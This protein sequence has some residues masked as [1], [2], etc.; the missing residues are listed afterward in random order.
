VKTYTVAHLGCGG[1]GSD[2]VRALAACKPRLKLIALC[3]LDTGRLNAGSAMIGGGPALYT[4][5]EAM[6]AK[7]KPDIFSFCTHPHAR[8]PFV[9]A[10]VRHGVKAIV[11]EKPMALSVQDA[12]AL[13]KTADAAGVKLVVS[14]QHKYGGH[15]QKVK[16]IVASGKIG[17]I[18]TIHATSLGWMQHYATHLIDYSLWLND[19]SPV[20]R[21][22]GHIHGRDYFG[23]GES[24]PS[25]GYFMG[26]LEFA[27][28]V[29]GLVECGT[30]TPEQ[31][32]G[33][34]FWLNAGATVVGTEG[35]A[36]VIVG[37]GWEAVTR[38]GVF[39]DCSVRFDGVKD[40]IPL[41]LE[42]A[43]WLDDKTRLHGCRGELACHGFEVMMAICLSGLE[44]KP[45]DL[46]LSRNDDV[47]AR[48]LAEVPA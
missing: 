39:S 35:I 20:V 4:D 34:P 11:T 47:T 19:Y 40:S 1:R 33:I 29:R 44:H 12:R 17:R 3:D 16:A 46:P 32:P 48:M 37:K 6:L 42:V 25:P 41:H 26:H 7:E 8:L 24:H 13:C 43:D 45:V 21:V 14:H 9:E 28:G 2:H 18:R 38:D 36:R 22:A 30:F 23:A 27:N 10:G 5:V 31:E 15:W